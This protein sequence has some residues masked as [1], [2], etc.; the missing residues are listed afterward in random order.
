MKNNNKIYPNLSGLALALAGLFSGSVFSDIKTDGSLGPPAETLKGPDFKIT[1]DKGRQAG[2]NLFHSFKIFNIHKGES[3]TFSGPANVK[4]IFNRVTGDSSS[5]IDGLLKSTIQGAD[6]FIINPQGIFFGPDAKLEL[7]GSFH[8]STANNIGFTDGTTFSVNNF[9]PNATL[10]VAAPQSF[11]FLGNN[12]GDISLQG[13]E[14]SVQSGKEISLVGGNVAIT[15]SSVSALNGGV[16]IISRIAEGKT[17]FNS[18]VD[19]EQ[20]KVKV[21]KYGQVTISDSSNVITNGSGGNGI[22]IKAGHFIIEG[23]STLQSTKPFVLNNTDNGS[24]ININVA[25]LSVKDGS[26]I[27]TSTSS[28]GSGGKI[29][30]YASDKADIIGTDN[31]KQFPS[32]IF[33]KSFSL[34]GKAGEISIDTPSLNLQDRGTISGDLVN[35]FGIS[36]DIDISVDNLTISSDNTGFFTGI[37]SSNFIQNINYGIGTLGK[38]TIKANDSVNMS[39]FGSEIRNTNFGGDS[40]AGLISITSPKISLANQAKIEGSTIGLDTDNPKLSTE[41]LNDGTYGVIE[42]NSQSQIITSG[43]GG[44]GLAIHADQ[45]VLDKSKFQSFSIM[46]DQIKNPISIDVKNFAMESKSSIERTGFGGAAIKIKTDKFQISGGST[47]VTVNGLDNNTGNPI[48]INTNQFQLTGGSLISSLTNVNEKGGDIIIKAADQINISGIDP[49]NKTV[50]GI[51]SF[52]ASNNGKPGNIKIEKTSLLSIKEGGII[53]GL[54]LNNLTINKPGVAPNVNIAVDTL[55]ITSDNPNLPSGI[56]T[57]NVSSEP[58]SDLPGKITIE[59]TNSIL[60][61]G[62]AS[63]IANQTLGIADTGAITIKTSQLMLKNGAL[64][65][66]STSTAAKAG[67]IHITATQLNL[68]NQATISSSSSGTGD[69]GSI[70]IIDLN[71]FRSRQASV[72]TEATQADGGNITIRAKDLLFLKNSAI[73]ASVKQGGNGGNIDIDPVFTILD[74]SRIIAQAEDGTGGNI[75]ITTD[76][77]LKSG[78]SSIDA[79]S[80]TG[81]NGQVIIEA[82]DREALSS[83]ET[84]P[85]TFLDAT[86][87]LSKPCASRADRQ[88]IQFVVREYE[89][90]PQAPDV[91]QV[92]LPSLPPS[93]GVTNPGNTV[94]SVADATMHLSSAAGCTEQ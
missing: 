86:S 55:N 70:E 80:D 65:A 32:G 2:T 59:A 31:K 64:I 94:A 88:S 25:N 51:V 5:T 52:A 54:Q 76:F 16:N 28:A 91:L 56:F 26:Q 71:E 22:R 15:T 47:L 12:T 81:I 92:H 61:S 34:Q 7:S 6:F 62:K 43:F 10:S 39:G 9:D 63:T 72:T 30:I 73:T 77:L 19:T 48:D 84:L 1:A 14:L 90:L 41:K 78:N 66:G 29:T 38:I 42:L 49:I 75:K 46:S 44:N 87:I 82:L 36:A 4:N 58:S 8:A 40:S 57:A 60:L 53:G 74:N 13:A 68:G 45:L 21:S 85:A 79:S 18:S 3:S 20:T 27:F 24:P 37:S 11:G 35:G 93:G 89:V 23:K 33:S 69:A 83:V 67:D 50:S 17:P